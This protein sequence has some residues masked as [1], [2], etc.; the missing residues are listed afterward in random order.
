MAQIKHL[1]S[2]IHSEGKYKGETN[3]AEWLKVCFAFCAVALESDLKA[4][5]VCNFFCHLGE[6]YDGEEPVRNLTE[7]FNRA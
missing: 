4:F 2:S 5:D 7:G 1:A 3:H 6:N